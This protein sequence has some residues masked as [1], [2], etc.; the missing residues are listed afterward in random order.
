MNLLDGCAY[1]SFGNDAYFWKENIMHNNQP[2]FCVNYWNDGCI[3]CPRFTLTWLIIDDTLLQHWLEASGQVWRYSHQWPTLHSGCSMRHP[4]ALREGL[5]D[6]RLS[7]SYVEHHAAP[8]Q[9]PHVVVHSARWTRERE[10]AG[11][12]ESV[13]FVLGAHGMPRDG[14]RCGFANYS[15]HFVR[16]NILA[17]VLFHGQQS[18]FRDC[19][20]L[21]NFLTFSRCK[22]LLLCHV[23]AGCS[24]L[25]NSD[26]WAAFMF[27]L[28]M[29][30]DGRYGSI[31][32]LLEM[33]SVTCLLCEL[34]LRTWWG[35][36]RFGVDHCGSD[37]KVPNCDRC[38]S[39]Y[40][41]KE[42][43]V[44]QITF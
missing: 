25:D 24:C 33:Q 29:G 15:L 44:A 43:T 9:N 6:Q 42:S 39:L 20:L 38:E 34:W 40:S 13:R 28:R 10:C 14:K 31:L 5:K 17:D 21:S 16:S 36:F 41:S 11:G 35:Q 18:C 32:E 37:Q 3:G 22:D 12:S 19:W 2:Q 1:H 27:F 30:N 26:L 8:N 4:R 23:R 7:V